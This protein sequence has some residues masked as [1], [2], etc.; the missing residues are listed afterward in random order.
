MA[1][2]G[3]RTGPRCS[4]P[5]APLLKRF[6]PRAALGRAFDEAFDEVMALDNLVELFGAGATQNGVQPFSRHFA[7]RTRRALAALPTH[8]NPF[9]WQL[10][11]GEF[12]R[13]VGYDWL[14]L[15]FPISPPKLT[16]SCAPISDV[17]TASDERRYDFI[18]LSNVLDWLSE[19]EAREMLRLA[20]RALRPAGVVIIRQLNSCLDLTA[21]G[22]NCDGSA[23]KRTN[24]TAATGAF[25]IA[26][27][28]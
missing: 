14:D 28:M 7:E 25:S 6:A 8:D 12:P 21:P 1:E 27:C 19:S 13:Q 23:R 10:L 15:Q 24:F 9:L 5:P 17:L 4:V 18:H 26:N 3:S 16:S 22:R 20:H 11:V 2:K